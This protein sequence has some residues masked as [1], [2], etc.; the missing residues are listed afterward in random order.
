LD[1]VTKVQRNG[2][3]YAYVGL[4]II[5]LQRRF[6]TDDSVL[7]YGGIRH[8]GGNLY[9]IAP[10]TWSIW[11]AIFW[12]GRPP[13]LWSNFINFRHHRTCGKKIGYDQLSYLRN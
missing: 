8:E 10:K 2:P 3:K 13:N 5:S 7:H 11:V 1:K 12:G 9:E 6:P 4:I